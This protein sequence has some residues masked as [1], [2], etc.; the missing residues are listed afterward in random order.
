MRASDALIGCERLE[1]RQ[2]S[3]IFLYEDLRFDS[4]YFAEPESDWPM[5]RGRLVRLKAL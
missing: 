4:L 5:H 3:P 2:R 1:V